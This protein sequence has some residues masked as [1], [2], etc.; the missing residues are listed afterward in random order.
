MWCSI[1]KRDSR[2]VYSENDTGGGRRLSYYPTVVV[3]NGVPT[4][5]QMLFDCPNGIGLL[6]NLTLEGGW[7]V[8]S[9]GGPGGIENVAAFGHP[10][11]GQTKR[12]L[13]FGSNIGTAGE[14]VFCDAD[15]GITGSGNFFAPDQTY[16]NGCG[17]GILPSP[18]GFNIG[19]FGGGLPSPLTYIVRCQYGVN[20]TNGGSLLG[21]KYFYYL[22]DQGLTASKLGV[23]NLN[24]VNASVPKFNGVDLHAQGMGYIEYALRGQPGPPTLIIDPTTSPGNQNAY[25]YIT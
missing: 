18:T 3:F 11:I 15:F 16:V 1:L 6:K 17:Q 21:G 24:P 2:G 22:N 10:T 23:I 4:F 13:S 9:I 8:M 12:I 19:E 25:I 20:C 5:G 14:N 7:Y